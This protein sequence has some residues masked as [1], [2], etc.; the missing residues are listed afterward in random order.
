MRRACG[1]GTPDGN[2]PESTNVTDA[3]PDDAAGSVTLPDTPVEI[4]GN[5]TVF[6]VPLMLE[7]CVCVGGAGVGVAVGAGVMP[8]P[9]SGP[10]P[11]P[12][13]PPPPPHAARAATKKNAKTRRSIGKLTAS[14]P[15]F[16]RV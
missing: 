6:C 16:V 15:L 4:A 7:V 12:E 14:Q 5:V 2:A 11:P 1:V 8:V 3:L 13:L 9:G 10:P